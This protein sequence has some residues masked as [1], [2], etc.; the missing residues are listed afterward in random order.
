MKRNPP[1]S[2]PLGRSAQRKRVLLITLTLLLLLAGS[3]LLA[4]NIGSASVRAASEQQLHT[5]L[6]NIRAPRIVLAA[7]VGAGLAIAGAVMQAIVRNVLA[8]PYIVGIHSGASCGAAAIILGTAGASTL[9]LQ[10]GA[11][12]G[13]AVASVVVFALARSAGTFTAIRILLA[14]VAVGYA[15][16]ALTS[17][18]VFASDSPESSRSVMFWLLGSLGL[19]RWDSSLVLLA[20]LLL[21]TA[22]FLWLLGPKLDALNL[23]DS[24]ALSLG[25]RPARFRAVLLTLLCLLIGAVVAM[26]GAIGFVGLVVPHLARRLVG[27]SHR[28]MLP[29]AALLGAILVVCADI[30]A[31]VLLAP[32]EIPIGIITALIGTPMLFVLIRKQLQ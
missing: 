12:V 20:I 9:A 28:A 30:I 32:Q 16:S 8:D 4:L 23:G 10:G 3:A 7:L 15:L 25:I 31:R 18:M 1:S 26:S 24:T 19:A 5:I 14:G 6:W 21:V 29:V 27:S 2:D 22:T 13:A 17:F 11:F